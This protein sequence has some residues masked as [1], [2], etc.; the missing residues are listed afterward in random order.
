MIIYKIN[1]KEKIL[2]IEFI[3]A[4]Y[5]IKGKIISSYVNI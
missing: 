4:N 1:H 3:K 5:K 2:I